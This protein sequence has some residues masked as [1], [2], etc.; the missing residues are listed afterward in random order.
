MVGAKKPTKLEGIKKI[1]RFKK[2][3]VS[4]D[5]KNTIRE[6]KDLTFKED[7]NGNIIEDEFNIDSHT[8]DAMK[9]GLDGYEVADLKD[10]KNYSGKGKR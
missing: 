4:T 1:K 3:I 8:W 6:L 5:C 7:K 10:R 2:I 9:Y